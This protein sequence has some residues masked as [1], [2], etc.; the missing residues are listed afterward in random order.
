MSKSY[1]HERLEKKPKMKPHEK[2]PKYKPQPVY[3]LDT[4]DF[5]DDDISD[6]WDQ[7]ETYN[8]LR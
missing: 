7:N 3:E 2:K 1:R 5:D 8:F 6:Y 4:E